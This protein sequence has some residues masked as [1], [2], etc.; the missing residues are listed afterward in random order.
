MDD[1]ELVHVNLNETGSSEN[2]E[3]Y[4]CNDELNL[5]AYAYKDCKSGD[6]EENIDPNNNFF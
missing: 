1:N 5:K 2:I 4:S 6:F 3:M